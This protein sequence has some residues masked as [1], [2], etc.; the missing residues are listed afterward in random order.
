MVRSG[1]REL[2][3]TTI[4]FDTFRSNSSRD[5]N[6]DYHHDRSDGR[7]EKVDCEEWENY[8]SDER[9]IKGS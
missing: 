9:V 4:T 3:G 8:E 1:H 5:T 7:R 6:I 2:S